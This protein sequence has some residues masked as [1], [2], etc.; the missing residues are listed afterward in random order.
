MTQQERQLAYDPSPDP[1]S[2]E[3]EGWSGFDLKG[4]NA[5]DLTASPV[6]IKLLISNQQLTLA[7]LRK[8]ENLIETL[9]D[10]K[11]NL[12]VDLARSESKS[13]IILVEI[14][15]GFMGGIGV[16]MLTSSPANPIIGGL[17]IGCASLILL[18]LRFGDVTAA[19]QRMRAAISKEKDNE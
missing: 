2:M 4:L 16:N 14:P 15:V 18:V 10:D 11:E 17:L 7:R 1:I 9:R 8:A 6:V 13:S 5:E 19:C 12:R 3:L